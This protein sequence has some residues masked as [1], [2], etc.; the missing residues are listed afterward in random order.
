M[1]AVSIILASYNR[2]NDLGRLFQAYEDQTTP[3]AFE[4]IVVDDASTDDTW[5]FLQSYSP[6]RFTLR[7][8]R[9][10]KNS[11]PGKAR[12][13]AIPMVKSPLVLFTGDDI[14]PE[15]NFIESHLT[16][17]RV[18][19]DPKTAVLGR[20]LWPKDLPVN[21][22]MA[23]IDGIGAQ[24][25]SFFYF[26]NEREYDFRHFYTSNIS[27]KRDLLM[28]LDSWFNPDFIYP[29]FEDVELGYRLSKKGMRIKYTTAPTGYHYHYHNAYSFTKRQYRSGQMACVL[30]SRHKELKPLI[31]GK[32]LPL[33]LLKARLLK[34]FRLPGY[35][36]ASPK[37][38]ARME[39]LLIHLMNFYEYR[40]QP[41]LDN[42]YL[43]ALQ[44][45]FY[46][47]I[48]DGMLGINSLDPFG[49]R[50]S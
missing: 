41:L 9:L 17:H 31:M 49:N 16:A 38:V 5:K 33:R 24:Q 8:E 14:L 35:Q 22:L 11:G 39:N 1:T 50:S 40:P 30:V 21:T 28:S 2:A 46:K 19:P 48:F 3:D 18:L 47:G 37:V 36:A 45:F 13:T 44:H 34:R 27:L 7:C 42:L 29:G 12:N 15:K 20:I 4:M 25:F 43:F 26:Q 23:H 32:G 10:D 6:K